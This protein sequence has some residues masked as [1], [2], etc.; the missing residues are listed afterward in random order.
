MAITIQ[1]T[2]I[3][4][5][6]PTLQ[7]RSPWPEAPRARAR[8]LVAQLTLDEKVAL[9]SGQNAGYGS[10]SAVSAY[11]GFTVGIPRLGVPPLNYEDGPQGVA[12]GL[13]GVTAW[14]SVGT[15]AQSW[16]PELFAAWGA[17]MGTEQRGKGSS[18]MLGPAV[19]LVRVPWTGRVFEYM[20]EDPLLSSALVQP[21][22]AGVQSANVSSSV[23]HWAFNSQEVNRGDV[24]GSPGMSSNVPERAARELYVPPY[25]AAID[26]GCGTVMCAFVRVNHTQACE[27]PVLLRQWLLEELGFDG[28]VVSDWTATHSTVASALAGL[29]V[30]QEWQKNATY[31]GANLSAAVRAGQVPS[32]VMDDMAQRVLTTVFATTSL[33]D[34][35]WVPQTANVSSV[36]TTPQHAALARALAVAGTVLLRNEGLCPTPQYCTPMLPLDPTTLCRVV[37]IGDAEDTVA[38]GGSGGVVPPYVVTPTQGLAQALGSRTTLITLDG[39]NASAAAAAAADADVAIVLV[40]ERTS[41][42]MDRPAL[43]ALPEGQDELVRAVAAVQQK[44]VVVARCSGACLMPWR[45]AVPAIVSAYYGG[46]EAGNALADVLLGA[47]NPAGKLTLTWPAS[48]NDTWLSNGGRGGGPVDPAMY[49]GTERGNGYPEVDYLEGLAVGYRWADLFGVT[50]LWPFGHGLRCA[51]PAQ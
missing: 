2:L 9:V 29:T 24:R 15:V 3:L 40:G 8:E 33:G 20:S 37:I 51:A 27:H 5:L 38:G 35:P 22:I 7:G 6:L 16:R 10:A 49:P 18:I 39:R 43:L 34:T 46:Q 42:G 12:D 19:A 25:A 14:P 4:A 48:N 45:D 26:A 36:V 44:T 13:T 50:P 31:F 21:Y 1:W 30:E 32:A 47:S 28:I 23:K 17:A 41:E 11:V